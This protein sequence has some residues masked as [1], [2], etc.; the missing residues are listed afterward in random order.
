[1]KSLGSA[2]EALGIKSAWI[3]LEIVVQG[4][5]RVPDLHVLQR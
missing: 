2:I 3:D 5:N 4:A 1:M